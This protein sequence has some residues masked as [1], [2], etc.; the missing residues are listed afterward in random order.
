M[1]PNIQAELKNRILV[2]DGAMGTMIQR[3]KLDEAGYRGERFKDYGRLLKGNND[4][5]SIT[6]P[7]I[8]KEIHEAYLEAGADIIETNTFN[9]TKIS[10][11]DYG[12][13]DL[14][15]EL[16]LKSAQIAREAA[17][18]FTKAN[19]EKPRFVAGAL[20]PTNKTASM[21]PEVNDPGYRAITFD[22]LVSDYHEQASALLEGGVDLLLVE[23]I[24]D[25][26]NAKAALF[27]HQRTDERKRCKNSG[28]GFGNHHRCQRTNTFGANAGGIF[29]FRFTYRFNKCWIKLFAWRET[30]SSLLGRIVENCSFPV[31]VYPNAGLPN[32]FGE[33]DETAEQMGVHIKDFTDHHFVN[34]VG[35]CC[36]TTP[37]HIRKIA[38]I[39]AKAGTRKIPAKQHI[40]QVS[41]LEP[42]KIDRE[43][44]FI[45]IGERT[46]VSGSRKFA[47]LIRDGQYEEA[48]S[49]AK[50]QVEGG[51][52]ILDVNLDD[53]MLDAEKEMVKF[54]NMLASDPE[55]AR[56]PIMVD[57]SKWEVIEAGLKCIQGKGIVNSIS[58]KNG[59][60]EF[61]EHAKKIRAYGAAVVVMAFDE[62][63]QAA[64]FE[65]KIE[66]CKRAYDLLTKEVN[67]PPEDIIFDPNILAIGTGIDE[68]NNY[69]VDYIRATKWIK[70]NLPFAKVSGGVSNLSFSFRGN[71]VVREA[72]NSI[73]LYHAIKAGMD[74]GIVNPG[75]LQI[76]DEIPKDL[77]TLCEDVVLNRRKDAT[78]RLLVYAEKIKDQVSGR[79]VKVDEWRSLPVEERLK[80]ALIKGITDHIEEDVE[81]TRKKFARAIEVIEQPLMDGMNVV[82][83]L[84]GSGKMFLPQVV[85]SA[86]VMKKAVSYLLPYIELEKVEGQS[87]AGKIVLATVKGDVH[88]IGKNI[89]G[90]VLACNNYE[91][92]DLGVMVPAEK[93]LEVVEKE[94][95]DLLGL[96]GL[97]TPSLEEMVYVAS[98]MKRKNMSIPLLIGGATTSSIH[99]AVKISPNYDHPIVH[100]RDAS[101]VIGVASKLLSQSEKAGFVKEIEA[102]YE[103]LRQKHLSNKKDKVYISLEE[104]R[105]NKFDPDWDLVPVTKPQFLGTKVLKEF[106]L[107]EIRPYIDWTFYFHA[108]KLNGKY[109]AIFNDPVKGEEAKKIFADAN[110]MLDKIIAEKWLTANAVFGFYEAA[111]ENDSVVLF[112]SENKNKTATTFHFLRN[113]E[114]KETRNS[115]P[116][117]V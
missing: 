88:D 80:H 99:T 23:T 55:I 69:A 42:L 53:G 81:E 67:F 24:F 90:V 65:R 15:Y 114:Q 116:L 68:H 110:T 17:D 9:G 54:L 26:L 29:Y 89:V 105:K 66:I 28:D 117:P 35:G 41:G 8:I 10:Q 108:W 43:K 33:Y 84:F 96:S 45:N 97:I 37:E 47:R 93:I 11:S 109:P 38:E 115:Q 30:N 60:A 5:L 19:P 100:V 21:S 70:E 85:K 22:R 56:L 27:C 32:Q 2:L 95:A 74:M 111:S 7:Q 20:G 16:N 72:I 102:E 73:F 78:E 112:D 76:Y 63:G 59:E 92:I 36:G 18:K 113:Q 48:L 34:I 6:Q 86:R 4:L 82:G 104:A 83:D 39:A 44:N 79:V 107:E 61:I 51:A 25:T 12:L 13:E 75:M 87:N 49:V 46:N 103:S 57:S 94:N 77:K 14:V 91:V 106:P 50:D 3:Y 1:K 31:S 98:E 101:K 71:D 58:M 52:Q 64:T 40:S 62:E